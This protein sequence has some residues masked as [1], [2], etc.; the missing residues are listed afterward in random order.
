MFFHPFEMESKTH[1]NV[2]SEVQMHLQNNLLFETEIKTQ[3]NVTSKV[4][5]Y[6]R[7]KRLTYVISRI[8][9]IHH[10]Q[11]IRFHLSHHISQNV[12]L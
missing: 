11:S 9:N 1:G 7:N 10:N 5:M 3:E 2:T 12:A 6:L 8:V 4:Q